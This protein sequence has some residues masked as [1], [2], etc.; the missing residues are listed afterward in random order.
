MRFFR[1][2]PKQEN[3]CCNIQIESVKKEKNIKKDSCCS[4]QFEEIPTE[5]KSKQKDISCCA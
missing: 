4:V 2:K 3:S 5:D 1:K